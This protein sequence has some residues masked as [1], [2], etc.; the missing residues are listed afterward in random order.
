VKL[1]TP[2]IKMM[3]EFIKHNRVVFKSKGPI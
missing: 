1:R 2:A 3:S